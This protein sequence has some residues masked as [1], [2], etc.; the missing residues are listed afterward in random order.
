M[1]MTRMYSA[2]NGELLPFVTW[3]TAVT[4]KMS[5][6][7]WRYRKVGPVCF[8]YISTYATDTIVTT[9]ESAN[10]SEATSVFERRRRSS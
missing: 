4:S 3:T 6:S 1:A 5:N 7:A 8:L 10:A 9:A 2:E